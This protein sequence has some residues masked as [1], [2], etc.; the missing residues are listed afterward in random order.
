LALPAKAACDGGQIEWE[1]KIT[2]PFLNNGGNPMNRLATSTLVLAVGLLATAPVWAEQPKANPE[3]VRALHE[4]HRA[5]LAAFNKGDAE[6]V[7]AFNAPDA[8]FRNS[9]GEIFKAH[10]DGKEQLT[11]LFA[12]NKGVKLNS[13]SFGTLRFL[14]PDVA[15]A[16]RPSG[17]T[18]APEGWP[19]KVYVTVVYVRRDGKWQIA[20]TRV[21]APFK[22]SR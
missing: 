4:L 20:A 18:P 12:Q 17:L 3:D 10:V 1:H 8:D 21:M 22:P 15:I 5:R 2:K 7:I 16:D 9:R 6:A 13:S 19:S 11:S 14:T